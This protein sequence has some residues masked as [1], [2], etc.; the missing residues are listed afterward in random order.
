MLPFGKYVGPLKR[1]FKF[2]TV[3][4]SVCEKT[5]PVPNRPL[6]GLGTHTHTKK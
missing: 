4:E 1:R 5:C 6:S 3:K 2:V